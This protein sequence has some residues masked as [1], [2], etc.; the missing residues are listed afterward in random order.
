MWKSWAIPVAIAASCA[1]S[2]L[3][4]ATTLTVETSS[5]LGWTAVTP[6]E[7]GEVTVSSVIRNPAWAD[8]PWI[9]T[10]SIGTESGPI[11]TYQYIYTL[12]QAGLFGTLAGT[13]FVDNRLQ[14]I[15]VNGNE[16]NGT[17]F[18]DLGERQFEGAGRQ[19]A[20]DLSQYGLIQSITFVTLN[21]GGPEGFSTGTAGLSAPAIPE[22][23]TWM[24]M[25][26]G[27]GAVGFAMRRRQNTSVRLQFA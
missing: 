16:A 3:A 20:F 2:P 15:F 8:V 21:N 17:N 1:A 11:G 4:A 24:L 13:L 23:G 7:A 27:L 12:G 18:E 26:L 14:R 9:S 5:I 22:P 6:G 19:I 25:I 10:R